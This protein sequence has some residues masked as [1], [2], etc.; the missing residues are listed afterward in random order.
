MKYMSKISTG[1]EGEKIA[2]AYLK[3]NGYCTS[4]TN[5]RCPLGEIDTIARDKTGELVLLK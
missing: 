3:K 5:F 2:V 4:E 1:K